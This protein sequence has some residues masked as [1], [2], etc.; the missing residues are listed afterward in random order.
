MKDSVGS[1]L[2]L[3][4]FVVFMIVY[5]IFMASILNYTKA[6]RI[7]NQIVN[8][9]NRYGSYDEVAA[10]E[11]KDYFTKSDMYGECKLLEGN[12]DFGTYIENRC[13]IKEYKVASA[14]GGSYYKVRIYVTFQFPLISDT[15]QIPITGETKTL[16]KDQVPPPPETKFEKVKN[17]LVIKKEKLPTDDCF[18]GNTGI[19][20]APNSCCSKATCYTS[21]L[22]YVDGSCGCY[23]LNLATGLVQGP[24]GTYWNSSLPGRRATDNHCYYCYDCPA[25]ITFTKVSEGNKSKPSNSVKIKVYVDTGDVGLKEC[26]PNRAGNYVTYTSSDAC[27]DTKTISCTD[28]LGTSNSITLDVYSKINNCKTCNYSNGTCSKCSTGY[29]LAD[30][31]KKCCKNISNCTGGYNSDCKCKKCKGTVDGCLTYD[32]STCKCSKCDAGL[33]KCSDGSCQEKCPVK[34]CYC[35]G[36]SQGV[37][38]KWAYSGGGNCVQQ[39][40]TSK[41]G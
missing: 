29:T 24:M 17:E 16:H 20:G 26:S 31:N 32:S 9:I 15:L 8:I 3:K 30:G 11:I 23:V 37:V 28:V 34:K 2:L 38:C 12:N 40:D 25:K 22:R 21:E 36:G 5:I 33:K 41:C 35:C 39:T 19:P 7:K 6:F 4:I 27:V 13:E 1:T 18:P 10:A 14:V